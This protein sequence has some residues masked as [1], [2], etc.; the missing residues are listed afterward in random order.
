MSVVQAVECDGKKF[1]EVVVKGA[2]EVIGELLAD[3]PT[4]YHTVF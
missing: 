2:P 4:N 3:R 1:A